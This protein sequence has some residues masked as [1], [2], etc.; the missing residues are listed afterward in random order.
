MTYKIT[1]LNN[2]EYTEQEL[3]ELVEKN[4]RKEIIK[5]VEKMIDECKT[6]LIYRLVLSWIK[7]C[8]N[9]DGDTAEEM[10]NESFKELKTKLQ[11]LREK[12]T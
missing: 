4:I 8:N 6:D 5:E 7:I 10:I 3:R 9:Q 12:W 2:R 11:E 1:D